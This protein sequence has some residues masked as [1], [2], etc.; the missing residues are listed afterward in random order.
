[1]LQK[2][3]PLR[4]CDKVRHRGKCQFRER[5]SHWF[6]SLAT[7][8]RHALELFLGASS[9]ECIPSPENGPVMAGQRQKSSQTGS[10]VHRS[11]HLVRL[12]VVC[13]VC[14]FACLV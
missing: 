11:G 8:V 7:A 14:L 5:L 9:W 10:R 13:F 1:M 6:S 2:K 12:W 4:K 3:E